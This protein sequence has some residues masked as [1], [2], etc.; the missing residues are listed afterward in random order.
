MTYLV[1]AVAARLHNTVANVRE[2]E[3]GQ[4]LVEY[5]LIIAIIALG[6]ILALYFLRD[7]IREIFSDT[8]NTLQ[9]TPQG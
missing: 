3:E 2:R 7:E 1:N 5:A 4:T 6:L 8:G 9:T